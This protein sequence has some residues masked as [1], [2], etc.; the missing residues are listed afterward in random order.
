MWW[1]CCKEL[2]NS[3][4]EFDVSELVHSH[5]RSHL[6]R[7]RQELCKFTCSCQDLSNIYFKAS[8][9][10]QQSSIQP[11]RSW[12]QELVSWNGGIN[13]MSTGLLCTPSSPDR[14]RLV[15]LA[16]DYTRLARPKPNPEP[17]RRLPSFRLCCLNCA[18]QFDLS[19][20]CSAVVGTELGGTAEHLIDASE[21]PICRLSFEF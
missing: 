5:V 1:K 11:I 3:Y 16:V 19:T 4:L 10:C 13:G 15:P 6:C 12:Y 7:L 2:H 14:S 8:Q 9:S 18:Q 17:V 21:K 20:T